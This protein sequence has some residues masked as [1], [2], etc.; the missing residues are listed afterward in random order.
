ML[1]I[2]VTLICENP[3]SLCGWSAPLGSSY[4]CW[5]PKGS[6]TLT[7]LISQLEVSY[8]LDYVDNVVC[9]FRLLILPQCHKC[10]NQCTGSRLLEVNKVF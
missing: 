3:K 8:F 10:G 2:L 6:L 7:T 4:F 9:F 1:I 5:E